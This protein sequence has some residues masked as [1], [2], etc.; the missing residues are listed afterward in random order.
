MTKID[1]KRTTNPIDRT[2]MVL[3]LDPFHSFKMIPQTLLNTMFK[4][5]RIL[6][7]NASNVTG[8]RLCPIPKKKNCRNQSVPPRKL[9]NTF[10]RRIFPETVVKSL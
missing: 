2:K 5:I 8:K 10:M 3:L 6:Q 1:N 4:A 9:N 7:P